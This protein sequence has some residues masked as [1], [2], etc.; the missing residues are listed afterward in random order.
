M[1]KRVLMIGLV[2]ALSIG[3]VLPVSAGRIVNIY[4]NGPLIITHTGCN[5]G[6]CCDIQF[7]LSRSK[8]SPKWAY[9]AA[10][11]MISHYPAQALSI[12]LADMMRSGAKTVSKSILASKIERIILKAKRAGASKVYISVPDW[13][14][15]Y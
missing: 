12:D 14:Y 3:F 7:D 2:I 15:S 1:I 4:N 8:F 5:S 9:K 10:G 11:A 13:E 6:V